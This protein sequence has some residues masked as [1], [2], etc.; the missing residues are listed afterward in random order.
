[1]NRHL[2]IPKC[3]THKNTSSNHH[4]YSHNSPV[5][6]KLRHPYIRGYALCLGLCI[7]V[8][9]GCLLCLL[10]GVW[11]MMDVSL[12]YRSVRQTVHDEHQYAAVPWFG[13]ACQRN[14]T[15]FAV[16]DCKRAA[17]QTFA[18]KVDDK[19]MHVMI[20]R[21]GAG[22]QDVLVWY[23]QWY[24]HL[25]FGAVAYAVSVTVGFIMYKWI[26]AQMTCLQ[27]KIEENEY[28]V[29]PGRRNEPFIGLSEMGPIHDTMMTGIETMTTLPAD[30]PALHVAGIRQRMRS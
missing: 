11:W 22:V 12:T 3:H 24:E 6:T 4:M 30:R 10:Y 27:R 18:E 15:H 16:I 20:D 13:Q 21:L 17:K 9:V 23:R 29:P 25:L 26:H 28:Q 5:E 2:H 7:L 19:A 8:C 14:E 1:M